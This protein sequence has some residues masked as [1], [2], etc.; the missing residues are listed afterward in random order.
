MNLFQYSKTTSWPTY[1]SMSCEVALKSAKKYTAAGMKGGFGPMRKLP[2][3]SD[4][5]SV[6]IRNMDR[7]AIAQPRGFGTV[8]IP[9]FRPVAV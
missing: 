4:R 3:L 6:N 8:Q 2:R 5:K 7:L 1:S 9:T